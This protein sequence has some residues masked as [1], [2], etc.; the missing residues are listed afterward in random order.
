MIKKL[1][2]YNLLLINLILVNSYKLPISNMYKQKQNSNLK[3]EK[4]D[5]SDISN[6]LNDVENLYIWSE[7][8]NL[9]SKKNNYCSLASLDENNTPYVSS[10][11]IYF[12]RG[13]PLISI[14]DK[15]L[16][17]NNIKQNNNI[18][19]CIFDKN[20]LGHRNSRVTL[21][22]KIKFLKSGNFKNSLLNHLGNSNSNFWNHLNDFDIYKLEI[23]NIFFM[24]GYGSSK[25]INFD[26]YKELFLDEKKLYLTNEI[27]NK[28]AL[29]SLKRKYQFGLDNLV[30][31]ISS[32]YNFTESEIYNFLEISE[33]KHGQISMVS[34][35]GIISGELSKGPFL[36]E[37]GCSPTLFNNGLQAI[38][39]IFW[40]PTLSI[41]LIHEIIFKGTL[42][43]KNEAVIFKNDNLYN[44]ELLNGRLSMIG[45]VF[46]IF[47]EY[48]F[49]KGII[50][51]SIQDYISIILVYFKFRSSVYK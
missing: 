30:D 38:D 11:N 19:I 15:S 20:K 37:N 47:Y 10:T 18:S 35:V 25:Q 29:K 36:L 6:K 4:Y 33:R 44:I 40:I 7:L 45:I 50:S 41:P 51:N 5:F 22:G 31:H 8:K 39:P 28:T 2:K 46:I 23:S 13:R 17:K 49:N 34:I 48:F 27:D 24:G 14:S 43:K 42:P 3:I 1:I 9:F 12:E 16:H 32:S 26:D 21:Q